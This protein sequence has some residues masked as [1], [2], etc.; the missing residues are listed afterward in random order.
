MADDPR[1]VTFGSESQDEIQYRAARRYEGWAGLF[2]GLPALLSFLTAWWPALLFSTSLSSG[3]TETIWFGMI[4]T[5]VTMALVGIPVA[6][7]TNAH[8]YPRQTRWIMLGWW[9]AIG[10]AVVSMGVSVY[11]MGPQE[12]VKPSPDEEMIRIQSGVDKVVW[13]YSAHC[14]QPENEGQAEDCARFRA[15]MAAAQPSDWSPRALFSIATTVPDGAYRRVT[16]GVFGI[17]AI[18]C[19][20]L[21]ARLYIQVTS[22]SHR[23]SYGEPAPLPGMVPTAAVTLE[24]FESQQDLFEAWAELNLLEAEGA[25]VQASRAYDDYCEKCRTNQRKPIGLKPFAQALIARARAS[26]A[27]IARVKVNGIWCYKGW[28]L[29]SEMVTGLQVI[30]STS[31]VARITHKR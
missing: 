21:L 10:F 8:A 14:R 28:Q 19:T 11:Q 27:H 23:V 1:T 3:W 26:R 31:P 16:V 5:V 4:A 9:L 25:A 24:P 18:L 6:A 17:L 7:V 2:L 12:Q 15:A 29:A 20:A 22:Q 13:R 30:G